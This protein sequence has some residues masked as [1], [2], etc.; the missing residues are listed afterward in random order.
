MEIIRHE[1]TEMK[2]MSDCMNKLQAEG[3]IINFMVENGKLHVVD[4]NKC[5]RPWQVKIVNFY[6]FEGASDPSDN[7]ILY[8]IETIDGLKGV[9]ADAYGVYADSGISR[10]IKEV[11]EIMKNTNPSKNEE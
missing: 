4:S 1:K 10:F 7:S 8:A 6:R 3:F 5:Y 2:S 11:N 9:I